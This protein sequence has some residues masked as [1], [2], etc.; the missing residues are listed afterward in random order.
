MSPPTQDSAPGFPDG[1]P[2]EDLSKTG[3]GYFAARLG[4][5]LDG[6][7]YVV[8]RKLGWGY[9]S[10]VWL[11][12][13]RRSVAHLTSLP[14]RQL[15]ICGCSENRFVA[16]KIL[17]CRATKVTTPG[18]GQWA[19]EVGMLRKVASGNTN[20]RGARHNVAF[21]DS[22]ELESA[23]G[24]H[25][26]VVTEPLGLSLHHVR[27]WRED[28]RVA[29]GIVKRL[30]RHVLLGLEYLHDVCG[31]VHAGRSGNPLA[32]R[33]AQAS[34][35]D[36]KLDN[37]ILRPQKLEAVILNELVQKPSRIYEAEGRTEPSIV[38]VY[39]QSLP[40]SVDRSLDEEN[41]DAVLADY[42]HCELV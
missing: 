23:R 2:E 33:V 37:I 16:V 13:D 27:Y 17:T 19:D 5:V 18:H 7:R 6:G 32:R 8:V 39:S 25:L 24:R 1:F 9:G 41:V 38:P 12:R 28:K 26:C 11:A 30:V 4:E 34:M 3:V 21:Y 31:I 22:F 36:L 15:L 40:V 42:G 20:H 10:S 29:P 14:S 35:V